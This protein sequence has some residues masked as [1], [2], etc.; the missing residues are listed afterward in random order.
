MVIVAYIIG[1]I[2]IL[3]GVG[4]GVFLLLTTKKSRNNPNKITVKKGSG[5][6][7]RIYFLYRI[8]TRVPFL[9]RYYVKFRTRLSILY[10]ADSIE[11]NKLA[12]TTMA[13]SSIIAI[14]SAVVLGYLSRADFFYMIISVFT[15]YIIFTNSISRSID[16]MEIKLLRQFTDF[17]TDVRSNYHSTGMV[18]DAIFMT[19]DDIP[20]EISL[21]ANR[22]Y[23]MVI[24]TDVSKEV[25]NYTDIAPNRFFEMFAAV[26]ATIKEYGD[27]E[28]PET[29]ESLFLKNINYIKEEVYVEITK[30]EKNNFL[31]SGLVPVCIAPIFSLKLI[32]MWAQ[33]ISGL[34]RFYNG[35][36]GTV[37]MA[38]AFVTTIVSYELIANLR[39]GRVDNEKEHPFWDR[40]ANLPF[41]RKI[42][43][44]VVNHNYTKFLRI[45]DDLKM[46]GSHIT[47]QGYL[48]QRCTLG[49]ALGV[50]AFGI[51]IGVYAT[52]VHSVLHDFSTEFEDS[53][54]PDE[55]YR[56]LMQELTE[57]YLLER[58]HIR[59]FSDNEINDLIYELQSEE[60]M[61]EALATQVANKVAERSNKYAKSYF[62]W[63][64]ILIIA[65][66]I[67]AGYYAPYLLL[68]YQ[69]SI[70]RMSM[71]DEV[72]QFQA[73]ALIL[74]NVDGMT[75]DVILEWME[76]F[77]FAFRQSISECILNLESSQS[78]AIRKMKD[79]EAFPPFRR[80]CDN[81]AAVDD[82]GV[83]HAFDEVQ[84]E[85]ENYKQQ[86]A[87]RNEITMT[88]K[89]NLAKA[90]SYMPMGVAV[91]GYLIFP[92]VQY[93]FE[94]LQSMSTA[95]TY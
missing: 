31:F 76:R 29:R 35:P 71:E 91:I 33:S 65:A 23:E 82:V 50:L 25:E 4:A 21:H 85:Q 18:E 26:C 32:A 17:L 55:D 83:S 81:L 90:I 66:A 46:V 60:G 80:F 62:K 1:A 75:I 64:Y 44:K 59:Q 51:T 2:C 67:V 86:R 9:N 45:G 20:Y 95:L 42:L 61:T 54:V 30:R 57:E 19:L 36:M 38:L 39:D 15:V 10:P 92:F 12:T 37:V 27:K 72:A 28:L 77:A 22:L 7:N 40:M 79:S 69:M 94:M 13:K 48:L 74:M 8:F 70:M 78:E 49:I 43:T 3:T 16:K 14:I 89:S 56:I 11:I 6:R 63:Y 34:S 87:L 47:H 58:K 88:R 84:T 24:S 41:I 52:N 73:L 93:A 53:I 5:K 68:K